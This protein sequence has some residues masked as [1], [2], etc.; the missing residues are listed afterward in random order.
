MKRGYCDD[1]KRNVGAVKK[2]FSWI[3]FILTG[4]IFYP[5]YR[6]LFVRRNKCC[7]CMRKLETLKN[8]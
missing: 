1:C 6:V 4:F 2:K 5:I 7:F 8:E 3:I